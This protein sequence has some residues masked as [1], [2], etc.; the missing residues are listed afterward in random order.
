MKAEARLARALDVQ[1]VQDI[2]YL[3][4]FR[5]RQHVS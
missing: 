1:P 3:S 2:G 4:V 5:E